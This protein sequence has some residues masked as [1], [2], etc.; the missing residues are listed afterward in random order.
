MVKEI[1]SSYW[2]DPYILEGLPKDSLKTPDVF[3]DASYV[4]TCRSAIGITLDTLLEN[5]GIALLPAFTCESVLVSFLDRG[6]RV[7]PYPIRTDLS[8]DWEKFQAKIKKIRPSVVLVHSYFGFDTISEIRSHILELREKGII[9]IE[10]ETQSMFSCCPLE[11]AN[12]YVGSIRKWIPIPDGAFCS[13]PFNGNEEDKELVS[14][15]SIALK[16]KGIWMLN[17]VGTKAGFLQKF[18]IAEKILDSRKKPYLMSSISREIYSQTDIRNMK[19][20]RRR[21]CIQLLTSIQFD[22]VLSEK[23]ILPI[24]S[25]GKN[26]CPFHLPVLVKEG[27]KELQ[28]YL[29]LNDIYATI[30]WG[31]PDEYRE[32]I[33]EDSLYVY[34]HILCFHVDQRYDEFDMNRIVSVLKE[35]Y[36]LSR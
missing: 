31:C 10:D 22:N 6:Y 32:T 19:S 26:D 14:A 11:H 5:N 12:F 17:R 13:A 25:V 1:G 24:T 30:I 28:Q 4:S 8:I 20:A 21:N 18:R 15:K 33:D 9:V 2:L 36:D 16:E 34:D 23:L 35:Y 27:R 29:A 3:K 7:Y